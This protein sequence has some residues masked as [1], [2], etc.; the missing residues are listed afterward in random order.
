MDRPVLDFYS[1]L[2]ARWEV[3]K[4][5]YKDIPIEVYYDPKHPYN[6]DRMIQATA[7][8]RKPRASSTTGW[9]SAYSHAG[10]RAR[11]PTKRS[12][13]ERHHI[14]REDPV[15]TVV[16]DEVPYEAGLDPYNKLIDRVSV[17]NRKRVTLQ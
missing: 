12:C 17:D 1:F 15:V 13:L 3:K 6:V 14:T 10:L 7:R 9:T 2:S 4:G 16:V 8:A 5:A 11:K